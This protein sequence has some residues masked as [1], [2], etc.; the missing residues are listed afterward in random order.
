MAPASGKRRRGTPEH[1]GLE[2]EIDI[3]CG[4]LGKALGGSGGRFIA[5]SPK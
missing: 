5:S 3:I 2:G 4:T 1:Y